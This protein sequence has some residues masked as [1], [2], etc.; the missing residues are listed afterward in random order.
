MGQDFWDCYGRENLICKEI[1]YVNN[2]PFRPTQVKWHLMIASCHR[3]SGN[4][5]QALETY[6]F[7]H[8]KFPDNVECKYE[9]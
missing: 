2:S 4:Y 9:G 1:H 5:Q 3:R 6:K 7:I 8:K